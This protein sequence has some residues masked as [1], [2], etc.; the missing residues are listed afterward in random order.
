MFY[1]AHFQK[2]GNAKKSVSVIKMGCFLSKNREV[3]RIVSAAQINHTITSVKL[4]KI[5]QELYEIDKKLDSFRNGKVSMK[6]R[7]S[8][9]PNYFSDC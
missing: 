6:N 7:Y 2:C 8:V 4:E 3:D 1:L 9:G 5:S